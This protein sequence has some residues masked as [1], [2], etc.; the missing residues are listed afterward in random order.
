MNYSEI[1][2]AIGPIFVLLLISEVLWRRKILRGE[3]ARKTLHIIIG[4]YVALWPRFL[5]FQ[6]IQIISV[7]LLAVVLLSHRLHLFH[8]INDVRRKTWG[9]SLYAVGIGLTATLTSSPW[10]FAVAVLHMSVAD[11]FAG[12]LGSRYGKQNQ[13]KVFGNTKSI[14]GTVTFIVLSFVILAL[15]SRSCPTQTAPLVIALLP[16]MAALVE[17]IGVRGTDNVMIPLL[18]IAAFSL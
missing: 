6:Q 7:A 18:I 13:Y 11:G 9:D 10:I 15:F 4:S 3:S 2:K 1:L 17:N 14:I 8:A 5:S 16:F 12:L